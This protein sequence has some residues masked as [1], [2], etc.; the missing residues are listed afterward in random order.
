MRLVAKHIDFDCMNRRKS[1]TT[2]R[3]VV[4]ELSKTFYGRWTERV[5]TKL[6]HGQS[7][8]T[9][10]KHIFQKLIGLKCA[11]MNRQ[12]IA[13]ARQQR[14]ISLHGISE[15]INTLISIR[16]PCFPY[17]FGCSSPLPT[18]F[19]LRWTYYSVFFLSIKRGVTISKIHRNNGKINRFRFPIAIV[20]FCMFEL[21]DIAR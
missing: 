8:Q 16:M 3:F 21:F 11:N 14:L 1:T 4:N 5:T 7:L 13:F 20:S 6:K 18:E 19:V 2:Q 17:C 9:W 10:R 15:I 12:H